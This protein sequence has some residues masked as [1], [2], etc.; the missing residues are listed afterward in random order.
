[1]KREIRK[2]GN[3]RVRAIFSFIALVSCLSGIVLGKAL[4]ETAKI[5][6]PETIVLININDFTQ[7]T[8]QFKK[9]NLYK[10]TQ[11]PTM[12]EFINNFEANCKELMQQSENEIT[13]LIV[14]ANTLPTGRIAL[15][16]VLNRQ[17]TDANQPPLLLITQW[18]DQISKIKELINKL[19]ESA[20]EDGA[21]RSIEHYRSVTIE[22]LKSSTKDSW[23]LSYCFFDDCLIGSS[24]VDTLKFVI[25]HIE[26]VASPTL[27]NDTDYITTMKAV[28]PYNDVSIYIN[29]KQII[30]MAL[31]EDTTGETQTV[32]NNLGFNNVSSIAYSIG[33][34]RRPNSSFSGKAFIKIEGEKKGICKMLDFES[35]ILEIARFIP[36]S[37]HSVIFLNLSI[38]RIYEELYNILYNIDPATAAVMQ[39]PILP[40]GPEGEPGMELKRDII[41]YLGNQIIIA[42]STQKPFTLGSPTVE[43][44]VALAV[45]NRQAIEKSLSRWHNKMILRHNPDAK[46]E[47]LGHTIY[48][49]TP[50]ALPFFRPGPTPM[51]EISEMDVEQMPNLAFTITDTHLILGLE[52]TVEQAI[53]TLSSPEAESIDT[54][55]WF[56]SARLAIPSVVGMA[57]LEDSAVAAEIFWWM[58]KQTSKAEKS[59][60]TPEL[61]EMS[62]FGPLAFN[63]LFNPDLLPDFDAVRKYFGLS[64]FYGVSRPDGFFFEFNNLNPPATD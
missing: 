20:V 41:D 60:A 39:V 24:D 62:V 49:L 4:P 47:L 1:M 15:A 32:I 44:L 31:A 54:A 64:V 34:A 56:T 12:T 9:T 13:K 10:L 33:L 26:G 43:T 25:A 50:S 57:S 8:N 51:Q 53:R 55:Q 63:Q 5:V 52:S 3:D 59:V 11:D 19:A 46:R 27:A 28:G 48:L 17:T 61:A 30:K 37:T 22:T 7:L 45:N 23:P 18:G 14:D 2:K 35:D 29:T 42:Q 58:I 38:K 16:L 36:A 40:P 6:P 21:H